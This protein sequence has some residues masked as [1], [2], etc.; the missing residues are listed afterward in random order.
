MQN[1]SPMYEG[2][3]LSKSFKTSTQ[4]PDSFDEFKNH[5]IGNVQIADISSRLKEKHLEIWG[6]IWNLD[7]LTTPL[8]S[9]IK[10]AHMLYILR[11]HVDAQPEGSQEKADMHHA[12]VRLMEFWSRFEEI[13]VRW[14]KEDVVADADAAEGLSRLEQARFFPVLGRFIEVLQADGE[15]GLSKDVE[16]FVTTTTPWTKQIELWLVTRKAW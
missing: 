16:E 2:S 3:Y 12:F 8:S 14:A 4:Y 1:T 10:V 15:E 11:P 9:S 13:L 6:Q 5:R 7:F